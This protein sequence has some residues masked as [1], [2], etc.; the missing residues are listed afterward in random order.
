MPQMND[1]E[2]IARRQGG[3]N[4]HLTAG[5][6]SMLAIGGA[7]GTGLFLGSAYAIQMAGPSVLLSYLIGGVIALLLMGSLAE[8]TSEHPTPGSFGDYAEFYLGPLFGFLVRYSYWSCVVLAVGTEVTAIGMYMQFWFPATPTWPWVLL[9]SAAV[10]VVNVIGVKSFGQVEYALSTVK[11]TAIVAFILI[12]IGILAFSGNPAYGLRNLTAGGF[13]PFGVKGMWFAVI[14]SIFSYLSIE[15]IAVAAG[16]A[17]NPVIAVKAAFKGTIVR[18]FIF[19]ML[20]IALMLAIVPWRQSGTGES[21]FLMAM[22]VIHLPAAAGIFNFIVLVAALSAMNSQLYITT[23]MMFSLSRAGQAPAALGR[24]SRR[25]IPVNALA[26]SCIG[27]V[28]SIV[29]SLVAPETSFAA[30][31]SISVYGACFTW[32][33]IFV[34]HLFSPPPAPADPP[35]VPHVGIPLYHLAGCRAD[36]GADDLDGVYRILPHDA[37]VRYSVHLAAGGGLSRPEPPRGRAVAVQSAGSGVIDR[38]IRLWRAQNGGVMY[39]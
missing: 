20:S 3:L 19:Y 37:V 38:L 22:N 35:E 25:G 1:F 36:G 27:I 4:K 21:P 33:M 32:L 10:I 11:V 29:L 26:M 16:E 12:G 8:M 39:C 31:M 24:V 14:V 2:H 6:M 34:T 9:F 17:K 23:R 13:M 18:L 30:M 28:V 5:Q 7:I 15:M